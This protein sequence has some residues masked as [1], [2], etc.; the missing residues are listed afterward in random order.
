MV[1]IPITDVKARICGLV[2]RLLSVKEH[3]VITKHGRPVAAIIPYDDWEE[4]TMAKSGGLASVPPPGGNDD[5][6]VD[7]MIA[8]IYE[9]RGR[10]RVR[11]VAI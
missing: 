10:A 1:T 6:A 11:K 9:A 3:I 4:F 5:A 8:G 7:V 2:E